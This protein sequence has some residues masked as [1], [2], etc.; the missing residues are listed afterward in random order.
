MSWAQDQRLAFIGE[1]LAAGALLRRSD[2]CEKFSIS[3]PQAS[4]D[5]RRFMEMNPGAIRL[6]RSLKGYVLDGWKLAA[7]S[8]VAMPAAEDQA[9]ISD[10]VVTAG[11]IP[12]D[13]DDLLSLVAYARQ[14]VK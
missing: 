2:I 7:T 10:W 9:I 12:Q 6:D 13:M 8:S 3:I 5:L 14:F 11:R 4:L 1:R